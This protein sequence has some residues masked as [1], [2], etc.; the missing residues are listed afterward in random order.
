MRKG[1]LFLLVLCIS[2]GFYGCRSKPEE[3]PV[4]TIPGTEFRKDATLTITSPTGDIKAV[5]EIEIAATKTACTQGL[6]YRESMAENRG[7]LF[8]PRSPAETPFWMKNTY[9]PLDIIFLD[10]DKKIMQITENNTPFSEDMIATRESYRY[11]LELNA[12]QAA[13]HNLKIGDQIQWK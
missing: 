6:M 2:L 1:I 4:E 5:Y 8:D 7:M 13:K 9:I 12:G 10:K 3:K 11:V